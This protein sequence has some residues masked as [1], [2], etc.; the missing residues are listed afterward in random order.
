MLEIVLFCCAMAAA[1][2]FQLRYQQS[3]HV[4]GLEAWFLISMWIMFGIF[5]G[6]HFEQ[7]NFEDFRLRNC[8]EI[9][10]GFVCKYRDHDDS[11][12]SECP[13]RAPGAC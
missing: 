13:S 5:I 8:T 9:K 2:Y 11:G 10:G 1:L 3:N 7:S 12:G 6:M 4:K